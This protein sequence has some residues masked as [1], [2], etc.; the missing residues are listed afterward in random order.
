MLFGLS[1]QGTMKAVP[2]ISVQI[3]LAVLITVIS[4]LGVSSIIELS[5]LK[6]REIKLLQNRG[7][8]TADRIANSLAYPLWNLNHEQTERVVLDEIGSPE[9]SAIRVYDENGDL[10]AGEVRGVD[11]VVKNIDGP[12]ADAA[13]IAG[14]SI[15]SYSRA[16]S[17]KN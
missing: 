12:I 4:V 10:Y 16:I 2:S 8:L 17:F 14:P 5:I 1:R 6:D 15:Y 9:I 13:I 11:G 3:L 7:S